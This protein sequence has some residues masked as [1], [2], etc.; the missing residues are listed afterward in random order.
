[1]MCIIVIPAG[2]PAIFLDLYCMRKGGRREGGGGGR[3]G[4]R[5]G[6]RKGEW[7]GGCITAMHEVREG[8]RDILGQRK[9]GEGELT[10]TIMYVQ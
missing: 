5:E 6:G 7:G 2:R 3:E 8:R 10:D 4:G 1:M 9:Q